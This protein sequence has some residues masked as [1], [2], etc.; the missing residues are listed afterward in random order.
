MGITALRKIQIGRESSQGT[1]VA[2]T[3]RLLG[4]LTME[5]VLA[6][7]RPDEERASL[8]DIHRTVL[9]GED[10]SL[11]F[12]GDATFEHLN[13]LL[14]NS[15]LTV[16]D[17]ADGGDGDYT[18]DY[19]PN[20]T[21]A[22]TIKT[23]TVEYGDD[24]QAWEAEFV[25]TRNLEI[26]GAMDQPWIVKADMFG[27]NMGETTFTGALTDDTVES[28]LTNKTVLSIDAI[29]GSIGTTAKASTLISFSWKLET[30]WNPRKHGGANLYFDT[31]GEKKMKL[32]VD[33]VI[34]FNS[35]VN[36]EMGFFRAGTPRLF[37][38]LST[39]SL[40]GGAT[41]NT[42]TLEWCG[43]YTKF[44]PLQEQEG[45][46]IVSVTIEGEYDA[47]WAKYLRAEVV[48]SVATL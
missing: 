4:K 46:D 15:I 21:T 45:A 36:T 42:A 27:R 16:S 8:A 14:E 11:S 44:S 37:Q 40:I 35:G 7:H 32:V 3:K 30:G 22:N 47:T 26:S 13:Y 9:A 39:G 20:L 25:A 10:V 24:V 48:S 18:R 23:F 19:D 41:Y 28:I 29:G 1:A 6:L 34:E 38:L 2:A 33:M 43:V 12:E 17:P 31:L 5:D